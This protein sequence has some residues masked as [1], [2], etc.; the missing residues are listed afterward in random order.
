MPI[1][2]EAP[3][4]IGAIVG[5]N[6]LGNGQGLA[7]QYGA[8]MQARNAAAQ[9]NAARMQQDRMAANGQMQQRD[10]FVAQNAY[11]PR[12][13]GQAQSQMALQQ[14][15]AQ[16]QSQLQQEDFNHADGVRLSQ[17]NQAK[18]SIIQQE[19][20][21]QI[22][23]PERDQMLTQLYTG[24]RG[25]SVL[26]NRQKATQAK[27]QQQHI[28]QI[29][30]QMRLQAED[31]ESKGKLEEQRLAYSAASIQGKLTQVPDPGESSRLQQEYQRQFPD[32]A[33]ADV[34]KHVKDELIA[35]GKFSTYYPDKNGVPTLVKDSPHGATGAAASDGGEGS[36]KGKASSAP[37]FDPSRAYHDAEGAVDKLVSAE[38]IKP[39]D[40]QKEIDKRFE[41]R[42]AAHAQYAGDQ[43]EAKMAGK[44]RPFNPHSPDEGTEAQKGKVAEFQQNLAA[45]PKL[46]LPPDLEFKASHAINEAIRLTGQYS[47]EKGRMDN[48]K[49]I[50]KHRL[51]EIKKTLDAIR[52]TAISAQRRPQSREEMLAEMGKQA[53]A[54]KAV[55]E[56]I[57][58]PAQPEG[59]PADTRTPWKKFV[60]G[61]LVTRENAVGRFKN[62]ASAMWN[63]NLI[64]T[65]DLKKLVG[66]Y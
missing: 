17:L 24:D 39:E 54:N 30:Q 23:I 56:G 19:S 62:G 14:Q 52:Q 11:S 7:E 37:V 10:Q 45:L 16:L 33:P 48:A 3:G 6:R 8:E 22:S 13:Q 65:D 61:D 15:H 55:S 20:D 66:G 35:G 49:P 21:G 38:K 29:K 32:M 27:A 51:A 58:N 5:I 25:I 41:A 18:A 26:D 53:E 12:D 42:K 4:P 44:P 28:E 9:Q 1:S 64:T 60:A 50:V 36:G 57:R 47:D 31:S 59:P 2:F 43:A 46:G 40:A 63:G 34:A